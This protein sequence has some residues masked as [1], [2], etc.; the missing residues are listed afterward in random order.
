M[1]CIFCTNTVL[2]RETTYLHTYDNCNLLAVGLLQRYINSSCD[3]TF[4]AFD[5]DAVFEDPF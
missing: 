4:Y 3:C 1:H 2:N 5:D